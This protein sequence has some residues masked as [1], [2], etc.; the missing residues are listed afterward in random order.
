MEKVS[1]NVKQYQPADWWQNVIRFV[2]SEKVIKRAKFHPKL[3]TK[4]RRTCKVSILNEIDGHFPLTALYGIFFFFCLANSCICF[5]YFI[6]TKACRSTKNSVEHRR[7]EVV[8]KFFMIRT[9]EDQPKIVQ[10]GYLE[11]VRISSAPF[12]VGIWHRNFSL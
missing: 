8:A 12:L 5:T 11:N 7:I 10:M 4:F 1:F 9:R 2:F 6:Y 3:W